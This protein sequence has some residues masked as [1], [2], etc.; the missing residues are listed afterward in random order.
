MDIG[1]RI[2]RLRKRQGRTLQQVADLCGFTKSL[3]CKIETGKTIPPIATLS[4][5]ADALGVKPSDLLA[6]AEARGTVFLPA[7]RLKNATLMRTDKGYSFFHFA[8][9][10]AAKL[11]EPY[12]FVARKGEI[13]G[14]PLTHRG[15]EFLYVLDGQMQF[16]VGK[17]E[18]AL[19]P[20]DSLYFDAEDPHD[21]QAVSDEVRYLCVFVEPGVGAAEETL[22]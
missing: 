14:E 7:D 4:R 22:S 6:E 20:G 21:L 9:E 3:L 17:I 1:A 12:L 13:G 18:Y 5:I 10:R 8:A 16:R 11:M 19:G 15:E 2:R